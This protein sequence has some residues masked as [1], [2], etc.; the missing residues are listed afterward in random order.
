L[1]AIADKMG[2]SSR[3]LSDAIKAETGDAAKAHIQLFIIEKAKSLLANTNE[4]VSNIG[5]DLGFEYPQYFVRLFK[6]K[7]GMTPSDFRL[8]FH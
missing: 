5:Y 4:P 3:Y 6:K 7:T 2:M 1:Q 8:Q